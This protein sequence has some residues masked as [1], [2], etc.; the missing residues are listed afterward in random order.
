MKRI[1]FVLLVSTIASVLILLTPH[2]FYNDS[3]SIFEIIVIASIIL[4]MLYCLFL[5]RIKRCNYTLLAVLNLIY[6]II[7]VTSNDEL[8][9]YRVRFFLIFF[10]SIRFERVTFNIFEGAWIITLLL[11][12]VVHLRIIFLAYKGYKNEKQNM[13]IM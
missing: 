1:I 2:Y 10:K 8:Q 9:Y 4:N 3:N 11:I 6:T 5:K 13:K 12:I 7:A